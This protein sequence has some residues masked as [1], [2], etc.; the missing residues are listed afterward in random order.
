MN[1]KHSCFI[2]YRHGQEEILQSFIAQFS[3]AL[4]AELELL[5]D[6]EIYRDDER[7]NSG[8]I[9]DRNLANGI[10]TS[11]CMIFIYTPKY[12]NADKNYCAREFLA[13]KE[14]QRKR[15]LKLKSEQLNSL[16]IPVILRGKEDFPD[17]I[18]D[19]GT[20]LYSDFEKFTLVDP[21]RII[22]NPNFFPEIQKIA[23]HIFNRYEEFK[24][25]K[26]CENC[27]AFNFPT[28]PEA[29]NWIDTLLN[30]PKEKLPFK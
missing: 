24:L 25:L 11:V 20:V 22:E 29:A 5:F 13:M 26:P 14:I 16:I 23:K 6:L 18:F 21:R 19:E 30:R 9:L 4:K 28:E 8:A 17:G 10:C 27:D 12:F 3:N 1:F 15:F 2:S 7:L